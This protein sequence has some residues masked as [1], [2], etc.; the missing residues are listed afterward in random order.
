VA[1]GDGNLSNPNGRAV[2]L[3]ITC[4]KK[5]PRLI[6]HIRNSLQSLLP[7]NKISIVDRI[8]CVD[9]GVYSNRLPELIGYPWDGGPK[10]VQDVGVQSWI[11]NEPLFTKECLRGLFQTDGCIYEDRG[12]LMVNF[13]SA[14][15]RL[16]KDVFRM[17]ERLEYYPR[18]QKIYQKNIYRRY[19]IRLS[20]NV[21][22]FIKEIGL[23]KE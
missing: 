10:I 22:S 4:D 23:W 3:R 8:G 18:M 13:T 19:T 9:I 11:K 21:E 16:A 15:E 14:G 17:M 1:L 2:R 5:Y 20:K 12:Y 7:E 6:S